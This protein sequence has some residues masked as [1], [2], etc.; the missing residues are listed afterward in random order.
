MGAMHVLRIANW[1]KNSQQQQWKMYHQI[2][3]QRKK[4][5]LV[6]LFCAQKKIEWREQRKMYHRICINKMKVSFV[7]HCA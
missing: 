2:L 7:L 6:G 4:K 1:L 5:T 3:Y